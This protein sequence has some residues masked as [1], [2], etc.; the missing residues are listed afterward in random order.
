MDHT[1]ADTD[2][3]TRLWEGMARMLCDIAGS[4]PDF[5]MWDGQP[6]WKWRMHGRDA[7]ARIRAAIDALTLDRPDVEAQVGTDSHRWAS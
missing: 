4:D 7:Q 2:R 1:D 6:L 5:R 3:T